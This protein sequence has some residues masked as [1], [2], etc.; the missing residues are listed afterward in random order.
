MSIADRHAE[1]ERWAEEKAAMAE[2]QARREAFAKEEREAAN[3][4]VS[5]A[6]ASYRWWGW[7]NIVN[8]VR[9]KIQAWRLRGNR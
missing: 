5:K 1:D 4:A 6:L 7:T 9:L 2:Y 3:R 8:T